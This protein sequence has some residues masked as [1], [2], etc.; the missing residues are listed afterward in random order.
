MFI[1]TGKRFKIM[2]LAQLKDWGSD[3]QDVVL[4]KVLGVP[5]FLLVNLI[6]QLAH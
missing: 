3:I 4:V 5:A 6:D 1:Y 2:K